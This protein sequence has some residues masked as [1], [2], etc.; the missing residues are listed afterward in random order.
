MSIG[1]KYVPNEGDPNSPIWFI[2]EAP[3]EN[4]E[5]ERRPFV[6]NAGD[7]LM[8]ALERHG[9]KRSDVFLT[10][11]CH[12][13]PPN[14]DLKLILDSNEFKSGII[15]L[16]TL[17]QSHNPN[18]IV[19]LG[20]YPLKFICEK[21]SIEMFR[22][23]II[24]ST[25]KSSIKCIPTY[26]P[27]NILYAP[28]HIFAFDLDIQRIRE[29]SKF[30]ELNHPILNIQYNPATYDSFFEAEYL[31]CDIETMMESEK[32]L[33][34]GFAKSKTEA[35]VFDFSTHRMDIELLLAHTNKKIFHNG[36]F[37]TTVLENNGIQVTNYE[38]DTILQAHVLYPELP[39]RLDYLSSIYT[40]V[41]YYKDTG[42]GSIPT[43]EKSWNEKK[44]TKKQLYEYNGTDCCVTYEI[45]E[46]QKTE[47]EG[48]TNHTDTYRYEIELVPL[49][50]D[51]GS[52]GLTLDEERYNIIKNGLINETKE[53]QRFLNTLAGKELN[54]NGKKTLPDY[55]YNT[56][57]L[58]KKVKKGKV[59]LDDS[60]LADLIAD[61]KAG[62]E[63]EKN[64]TKKFEWEV[65]LNM[66]LLIRKL[67]T[68]IKLI[69]SYLSIGLHEGKVK[70]LIRP[71]G[72]ETGRPSSSK[73]IDGSGLSVMTIPRGSVNIKE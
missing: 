42:R 58:K 10:N 44:R 19:P 70:S 60:A 9:L 21:N 6:G 63:A 55:I 33:C 25:I 15:E 46:S 71:D 23:S 57:K 2:G 62:L 51:I 17:M 12:Y 22:G 24:P 5:Q 68:S 38:E 3:G 50:R 30:P 40:R 14:N 37:D 26:H 4:E 59:K 13:R 36:I 47:I 56:L 49:L 52:Y 31:A 39:R 67:R 73:Y 61:C 54:V 65:K 66:I 28:S 35:I 53:N 11:L 32:I 29:D 18:V 27:S 41:P 48:D 45:W 16:V 34:V 72:T 64:E 20:H 1:T 43:D 69:S 7:V 8:K